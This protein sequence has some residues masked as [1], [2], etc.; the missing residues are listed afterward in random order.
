METGGRALGVFW[1][2]GLEG[3]IERYMLG[4]DRELLCQYAVTGV[5]TLLKQRNRN[6]LIWTLELH[7][8][9]CL[10][11]VYDYT[12]LLLLSVL[13]DSVSPI[14]M[15]NTINPK[16]RA[17]TFHCCLQCCI[18]RGFLITFTR[19]LRYSAN[20]WT[21]MGETDEAAITAVGSWTCRYWSGLSYEVEILIQ[22]PSPRQRD[23]WGIDLDSPCTWVGSHSLLWLSTNHS[24]T[25]QNTL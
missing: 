13:G 6:F 19:Q 10:L 24:H 7:L 21:F 25:H 3:C 15:E 20:F 8:W 16:P 23:L 5:I 2:R 17:S 22:S 9:K 11:N 18:F 12:V 1:W 14:Y 4:C